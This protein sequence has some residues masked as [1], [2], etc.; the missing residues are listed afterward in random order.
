MKVI[1]TDRLQAIYRYSSRASQSKRN[2]EGKSKTN[3]V[4]NV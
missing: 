2:L 3:E 4:I 1:L